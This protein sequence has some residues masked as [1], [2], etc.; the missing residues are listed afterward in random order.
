MGGRSSDPGKVS[1][2][3]KSSVSVTCFFFLEG[4][5]GGLKNY[6]DQYNW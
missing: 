4:G 2:A 1:P 6:F 3:R 5:V